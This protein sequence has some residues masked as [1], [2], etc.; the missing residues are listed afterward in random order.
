MF[1]S[2]ARTGSVI[3]LGVVS[4]VGQFISCFVYQN[5]QSA[6]FGQNYYFRQGTLIV[7]C[8]IGHGCAVD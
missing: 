7:Y 3:A 6:T 1:S 4:A 2:A 5:T 8:S